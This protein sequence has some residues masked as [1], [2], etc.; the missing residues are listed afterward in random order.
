MI[1]H[2]PWP[3]KAD[4]FTPAYLTGAILTD[5]GII[6]PANPPI[7]AG[8][9]G[10]GTQA[11]INDIARY[12]KVYAYEW[13]PRAGPGILQSPGYA[14]GAGHAS[15]LAY[16]WPNFEQNGVRISSLFDPGEQRL[17]DQIVEY[18][19]AFV[20]AGA[21]RAAGQP[22][23]PP[24]TATSA[25]Q[26]SLRAQGHSRLLDNATIAT[27]HHCSLWNKLNGTDPGGP[28]RPSPDR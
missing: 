13:A 3:A 2:Y 7:E 17:S 8:I 16:L 5:A 25:V 23:W 9:G 15:E 21:P 28:P 6:G 11:L 24:Y 22:S 26:L 12:T 14:N 20:K 1:A 18:W 4:Q 27:E 19:G 10:C